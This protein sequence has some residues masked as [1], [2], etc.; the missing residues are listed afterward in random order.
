MTMTDLIPAGY[1]NAVAV[2]IR[3]DDS[4]AWV[5]FGETSNGNPQVVVQF[6]IMDGPQAGR[7]LAWFG[8]FTPD[9]TKRTVEALRLCG[10]RGDDLADLLTQKINQQVSIVV[11][12]EEYKGKVSARV[13]WVNAP[14]GGGVRLANPMDAKQLRLFGAKMKM[15]VK[16]IGEVAGQAVEAPAPASR[17]TASGNGAGEQQAPSQR[18][19][20]PPHDDSEIPF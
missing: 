13:A 5:Q 8:Y 4:E 15:Q 6:A 11:T 20:P 14:G 2:P 7:R 16:G 9:T 10:F 18:E 12:H 3:T 1:Y 17:S 19:E